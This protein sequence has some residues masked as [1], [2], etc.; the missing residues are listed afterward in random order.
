MFGNM[1]NGEWTVYT[2]LSLRLSFTQIAFTEQVTHAHSHTDNGGL[3]VSPK[4]V[5]WTGATAAPFGLIIL[6]PNGH[7]SFFILQ[8]LFH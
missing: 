7:R 5:L 6:P 1:V 4:D 3:S 8:C 2:A